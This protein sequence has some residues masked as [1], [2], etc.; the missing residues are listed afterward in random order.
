[1]KVYVCDDHDHFWPVGVASVVLADGEDEARKLLDAALVARGLRPHE[2]KPY[3]LAPI[4]RRG[5]YILND[6]DH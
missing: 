2:D 5:A 3:T 6:G 4:E 1:V